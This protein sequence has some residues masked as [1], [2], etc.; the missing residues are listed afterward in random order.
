MTYKEH[1]EEV[2]K[3]VT[4]QYGDKCPDFDINCTVCKKWLM[5]KILSDCMLEEEQLSEASHMI[6]EKL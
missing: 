3:M 2:R 5:V 6:E 1:F 4:E